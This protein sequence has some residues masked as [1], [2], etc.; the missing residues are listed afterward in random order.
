MYLWF[1]LFSGYH[2]NILSEFINAEL[3]PVVTNF[4]SILLSTWYLLLGFAAAMLI[5]QI[6]ARVIFVQLKKSPHLRTTKIYQ[7]PSTYEWHDHR[8]LPEKEMYASQS[9]IAESCESGVY[10]M[11]S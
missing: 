8:S 4:R 3:S 11:T 5:F 6:T 7:L 10:D 2:E 1:F 9:V